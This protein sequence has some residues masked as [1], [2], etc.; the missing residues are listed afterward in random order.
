MKTRLIRISIGIVVIA[1]VLVVVA[2]VWATIVSARGESVAPAL[3]LAG[4]GVQI[5][6]GLALA[7]TPGILVWLALLVIPWAARRVWRSVE[8]NAA[9]GATRPG[10]RQFPIR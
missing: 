7:A 1:L 5:L 2:G 9:Q 4:A 3:E 6:L 10:H 8:L